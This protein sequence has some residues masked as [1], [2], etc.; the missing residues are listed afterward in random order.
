M[1]P[2]FRSGPYRLSSMVQLLGDDTIGLAGSAV[3]V[4]DAVAPGRAH[5]TRSEARR[6]V[7]RRLVDRL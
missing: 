3:P 1:N 4:D 6:L 5:A 7:R 2:P